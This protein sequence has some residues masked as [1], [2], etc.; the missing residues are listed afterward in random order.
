MA[1]TKIFYMTLVKVNFGKKRKKLHESKNFF[2]RT[3][4]KKRKKRKSEYIRKM[5]EDMNITH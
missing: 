2:K 5:T 1:R 3:F 4:S